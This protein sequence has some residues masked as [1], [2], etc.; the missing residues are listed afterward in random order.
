MSNITFESLPP[1]EK[2]KV[3]P[4]VS[5]LFARFPE[6]VE[7][8]AANNLYHVT[9]GMNVPGIMA[10][11]LKSAEPFP[12]EHGQFLLDVVA[13]HISNSVL[14]RQSNDYIQNRILNGSHVF[15]QTTKPNLSAQQPY[16]VPER[17]M[18]LMRGMYWL[19]HKEQLVDPQYIRVDAEQPMA[20]GRAMYGVEATVAW[21]DGIS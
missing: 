7:Q 13:R 10:D 1:G 16:A 15:L 18:L 21:L 3:R 20:A 11:G 8:Y 2:A 14:A 4:A 5:A 12:A 9:H 17:L 6:V 19:A